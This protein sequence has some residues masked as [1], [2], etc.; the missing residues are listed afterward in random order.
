VVLKRRS[1]EKKT[2]SG[3]E[4]RKRRVRTP[5]KKARKKEGVNSKRVKESIW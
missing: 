5:R 3:A 2:K 4:K 1:A